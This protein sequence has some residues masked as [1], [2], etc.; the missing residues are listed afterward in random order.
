LKCERPD[1]RKQKKAYNF[2][3]DQSI[4]DVNWVHFLDNDECKGKYKIFLSHTD[5]VS[6]PIEIIIMDSPVI[7]DWNKN[8]DTKTI[9]FT[10]TLPDD[11]ELKS[12]EFSDNFDFEI[13]P[14][15]ED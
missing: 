7:V 2:V 5:K 15:N 10:I 9:N 4:M 12:Y 8:I 1:G 3:S 11:I 14:K 13:V 6:S